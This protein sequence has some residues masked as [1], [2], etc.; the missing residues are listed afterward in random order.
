MKRRYWLTLIG[1]GWLWPG[2]LYGL[3]PPATNQERLT[4]RRWPWDYVVRRGAARDEAEREAE[5]R[6]YFDG[7]RD[8]L[9][10][11]REQR[12][13]RREGEAVK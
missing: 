10:L 6:T 12:R 2:G 4:E 1:L 9:W 7:Y 3:S 5:R 8:W 13:L 11:K